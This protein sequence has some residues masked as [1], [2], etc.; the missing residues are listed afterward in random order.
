[1]RGDMPT[2]PSLRHGLSAGEKLPEAT[3]TAWMRAT[4]TDVHEAFG[5]SECST[6]ISGSPDHPAPA[7]ASGFAQ[8]GRKIG[9]IENGHPVPRGDVGTIAIDRADAGLMLG[10]LNAPEDTAETFQGE[11]FL[12]GD[13]GDHGCGRCGHLC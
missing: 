10:Y 2:L 9:I 5:M 11:W 3:T 8:Q 12:T 1:M 6:F 4:G 13:T 7:G